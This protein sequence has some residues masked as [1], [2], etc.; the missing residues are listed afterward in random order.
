MFHSGQP[1]L[2]GMVGL[3]ALYAG[4]RDSLSGVARGRWTSWSRATQP[5][6]YFA[7][8]ATKFLLSAVFIVASVVELL[9]RV[10]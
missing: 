8:M 9:N 10:G 1:I 7:A 4:V 6:S 5:K 2:L 3:Y